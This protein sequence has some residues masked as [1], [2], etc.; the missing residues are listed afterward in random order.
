MQAHPVLRAMFRFMVGITILGFTS[1]ASA[2]ITLVSTSTN[3]AHATTSL[4]ITKPASINI[5]DVMI[6]QIAYNDCCSISIYAPSGWTLITE[7][8]NSEGVGELLEYRVVTASEPSSYTWSFSSA[9][10][11]A[12]GIVDYSGVGSTWPVDNYSAA[13]GSGVTMTAPAV[14]ATAATDR[15]LALFGGLGNNAW[16]DPAG[17]VKRW[18]L[19]TGPDAWLADQAL[20]VSGSTGTRTSR[21]T[22]SGYWVA[23][24]TALYPA[25]IPIISGTTYYVDS[26]GGN[27]S[28]SGTSISVAW[29]TIAH[30]ETK[31]SSLN[32]GDG[33]LF[34]GGD[35]WNEEFDLG[36][37]TSE[38]VTGSAPSPIVFSS[39]GNGQPILDEYS[40]TN[41]S[42]TNDYCNFCV[43]AVNPTAIN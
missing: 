6:A 12:G 32:P 25:P 43:D 5:G 4:I 16:T 24:L 35:T 29:K 21:Q 23:A 2:A 34:K 36:Q 28:N 27:D 11:T 8:D 18:G 37:T 7:N 40:T 10:N 22:I 30:V 41:C 38:S 9:L 14:T 39:Y 3:T 20:S 42:S 1:V 17:M 13:D 26:V 19:H 31:L 15:L 33:V